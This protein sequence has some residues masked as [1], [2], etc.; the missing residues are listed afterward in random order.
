[1]ENGSQ[2]VPAVRKLSL[3]TEWFSEQ[4]DGELKFSRT[5]FNF[6][7]ED[8]CAYF[9]QTA[10]GKWKLTTKM[11]NECLK[12]IPDE[13]IYPEAPPHVTIASVSTDGN[14]NVF[15]KGP[16]LRR[17]D[18]LKGTGIAAKLLL[19]E[20]EMLEFLTNHKQHPNII[21][22]HGCMAVSSDEIVLWASS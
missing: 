11:V 1:M 17:Y 18:E 10:V 6:V 5:T 16:K 3:V 4:D 7:T 2:L 20:A 15:V 14:N 12:R 8:Y 21:R 22:Y 19:H 13:D 9:G